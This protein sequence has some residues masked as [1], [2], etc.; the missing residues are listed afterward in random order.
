MAQWFESTTSY[1]LTYVC[2]S[3][4]NSTTMMWA[5]VS[6]VYR[7][8]MI[9]FG[10]YIHVEVFHSSMGLLVRKSSKRC[11]SEMIRDDECQLFYAGR[12]ALIHLQIFNQEAVY[13][14]MSTCYHQSILLTMDYLIHNIVFLSS[15]AMYTTL[16]TLYNIMV[17]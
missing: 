7:W 2:V 1:C 14:C 17:S 15:M 5:G 16:Y 8:N 11:H 6:I 3:D 9:T 13:I 4:T 10:T 12:T